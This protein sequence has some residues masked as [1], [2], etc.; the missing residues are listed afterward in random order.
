[1][2]LTLEQLRKLLDG[3]GLK[4]YLDPDRTAVLLTLGGQNGRYECIVSLQSEG[5]FLQLLTLGYATCAP[6]HPH[7]AA[8]FQALAAL[9]AE[10][11]FTKFA[12]D[13][14][15]SAIIVY[16]DVWLADGTL[17]P[18]QFQR[19]CSNYFG[20]LDG[21]AP[22]IRKALET[23]VDPGSDV[24]ATRVQPAPGR[25]PEPPTPPGPGPAL[26]EV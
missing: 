4:Y 14:K 5:Q 10:R 17:T 22:R 20:C 16:A 8:V 15:Q 3:A 26:A 7:R 23:G 6:D 18:A 21:D 19:M 11:R 24:S 13:A 12:W 9:N 25:A 1:M 2:A